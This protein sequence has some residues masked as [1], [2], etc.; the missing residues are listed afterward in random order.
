LVLIAGKGHEGYQIVGDAVLDFDDA[1][2]AR[3]LLAQR[4]VA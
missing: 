2:T 1:A 4:T 3:E